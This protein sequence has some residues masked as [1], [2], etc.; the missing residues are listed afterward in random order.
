MNRSVTHD[1]VVLRRILKA[2][3]RRVFRAWADEA[4]FAAWN[5]PGDERWSV[6]SKIHEFRVG[7]R[8][9]ATFRGPGSPQYTE[10]CRYEDIVTDKRICYAMT[11]SR[12]DVHITTSMVTIEIQPHQGGTELILTDQLAILDDAET[13]SDRENGWGESLDKLVRALEAAPVN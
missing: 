4:E 5:V 7:G 6:Q 10:D 13:P 12:D 11:I 9:L 3:P 2:S 8:R 1:T